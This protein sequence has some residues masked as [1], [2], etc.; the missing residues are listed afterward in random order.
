MTAQL[1]TLKSGL[2]E[3]L[4]RPGY[5]AAGSAAAALVFLMALALA[6]ARLLVF[7]LSSPILTWRQKL[8]SAGQTL[9]EGVIVFKPAILATTLVMA[10]LFGINLAMVAYYFKYRFALQRSVGTSMAGIILGLLGVGCAACGSVVLSTILGS[11]AALGVIGFLPLRGLEFSLIGI[12]LLAFSIY[13]TSKKVV[14]TET[15]P[16]PDHQARRT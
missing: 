6:S 10:V 9:V 13:S 15:C 3:V 8:V 14:G 11:G 7:I 2:T 16:M 12:L 1:R 5:L 4:R